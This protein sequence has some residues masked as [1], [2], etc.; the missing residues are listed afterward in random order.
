MGGW[1]INA[2]RLPPTAT[3]SWRD[4]FRKRAIPATALAALAGATAFVM[5][6][7]P[8]ISKAMDGETGGFKVHKTLSLS[9]SLGT[10]SPLGLGATRGAVVALAWSQNGQRLAAAYDYGN[11][12][13][14][15][16][17]SG[18]KL[19]QFRNQAVGGPALGGG[20]LIFL[21]GSSQLALPPP[22]DSI[23][24]AAI[25]LWDASMGAI[26]RTVPGPA[27]ANPDLPGTF[28]NAAWNL[29]TTPDQARL[30]AASGEGGIRNRYSYNLWIYDTETWRRLSSLKLVGGIKSLAYFNGG[31]LVAIGSSRGQVLILN[32]A[33][34]VV[35]HR[36]QAQ[37]VSK[38]GDIDITAVAGSPDGRW[39]MAGIGGGYIGGSIETMPHG[40]AQA[41]AWERSLDPVTMLRA[42]DGARVGAL[43]GPIEPIRRAAWDPKGRYVAILDNAGKLFLWRYPFSPRTYD[44][45]DLGANNNLALAISPSGDR[46]AVPTTNGATVYALE[47]RSEISVGS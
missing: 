42:S 7:H 47:D 15:W 31:R 32:P 14:V 13:T 44:Q 9:T 12:L 46:I 37:D 19:T 20:A 25:G 43:T 3:V 6:E 36:F 22:V 24:D 40:W 21:R 8:T 45:I 33:N 26:V 2:Q 30:A 18:R 1:P 5:F 11:I 35:L 39:I 4:K 34:A 29:A 16:N 38:F 23:N 10:E 17:S 27:P 28:P 41:K